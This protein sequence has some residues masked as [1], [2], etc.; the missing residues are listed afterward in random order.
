MMKPTDSHGEG[1]FTL[2]EL[3]IV[4]AIIGVLASVAVP[5]F[6]NYQYTAKTAE[7]TTNVGS[8]AKAQKAFFAE[9][10]LFVAAA[11]EPGATTKEL[12]TTKQRAVEELSIAFSA[13][14]W[15][16]TGRVYF[17]YDTSTK[18]LGCTSGGAFT[19]T[20]YGDVDGDGLVS[21]FAFFH[22][23]AK[24]NS[25]PVSVTGHT[26]VKK[27]GIMQWDTVIRHPSGAKF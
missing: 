17:D 10:G 15:T 16:P 1:G 14:G 18:G 9:Y 13:V 27:D 23:D 22:P 12:P 25:C 20:A 6:R 8:L 4:V 26:A 2:V 24:G 7:A 11:P 3:M 5:S 21:E 19:A